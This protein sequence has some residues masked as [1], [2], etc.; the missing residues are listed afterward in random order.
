MLRYKSAS[1]FINSTLYFHY[2]KKR[3]HWQVFLFI[4]HFFNKLRKPFGNA[5]RLPL[6]AIES[7]KNCE[8]KADFRRKMERN[9]ARKENAKEFTTVND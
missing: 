4:F 9:K 7:D 8:E 6:F 2:N 3:R 5:K 1:L